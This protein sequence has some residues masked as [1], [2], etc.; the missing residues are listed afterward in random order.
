MFYENGKVNFYGYPFILMSRRKT[1]L[2]RTGKALRA[3]VSLGVYYISFQIIYLVAL[4][5]VKFMAF[6]IFVMFEHQSR[7]F[8]AEQLKEKCV[9]SL[10]VCCILMEYS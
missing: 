1:K 7:T 8:F 9:R 4:H 3:Y 6:P 10:N 2:R 5:S